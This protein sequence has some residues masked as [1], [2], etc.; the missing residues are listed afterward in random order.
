[1]TNET[2]ESRQERREEKLR[3]KTE[4]IAKHGKGVAQ[5]YR[6]AV[7]KRLDAKKKDKGA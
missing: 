4:R 6:N 2:S 7:I 5:A 3:K 1:M